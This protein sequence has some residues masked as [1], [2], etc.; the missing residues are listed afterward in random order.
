[1]KSIQNSL[2]EL[3]LSL[4]RPLVTNAAFS[5]ARNNLSHTAFIALNKQAIVAT[6]YAHDHHRFHGLRVLAVDGSKV[7]LPQSEAVIAHFGSQ[8][9]ANQE[10]SNLG[11]FSYGLASVLYDVLNGIALDARLHPGHAYEVDAAEEHLSQAKKDDV[12]LFDRG[13]CSFRMMHTM[14]QTKAHFVMRCSTRSFKAAQEMFDDVSIIDQEVTLTPNQKYR[15]HYGYEGTNP[16]QVRFVRVVLKTGEVEVLAT[17]LLDTKKYPTELFSELYWKRWGVES[18]Y[19]II[20]S[21][22]GLENFSGYSVESILQEFHA[23]IFLTGLEAQL[24]EDS[25]T[26]LAQKEH[27]LQQVNH[28]VSFNAI[29]HRAF[30]LLVSDLPI[31]VV[32]A[33]L[34]KVFLKRP[35]V[36]AHNKSPVRKVSSATRL[37][38]FWK[39]RRKSVF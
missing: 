24:T 36:I 8:S 32:L 31:D 35:L 37:L 23:T 34:T 7:I 14:A 27:T 20:K 30:D 1:M 16:L 39:R 29:K 5:K 12:L 28:A 17:S 15:D 10:Y 22:L 2:N 25:D 9:I 33:E 21:R 26:L 13:Y 11:T 18:F 38:N 6:V 3:F 4:V 19:G